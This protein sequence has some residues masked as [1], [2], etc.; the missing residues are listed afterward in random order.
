ML[1]VMNS[2]CADIMELQHGLWQ[3]RD[4]IECRTLADDH[5]DIVHSPLLCLDLLTMQYV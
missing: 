2:H 5:P 1:R 3:H 4:M